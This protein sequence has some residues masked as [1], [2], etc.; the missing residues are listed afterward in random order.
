MRIGDYPSSV[1]IKVLASLPQRIRGTNCFMAF[2]ITTLL[3][4][5]SSQFYALNELSLTYEW[6]FVS[7]LVHFSFHTAPKI[8]I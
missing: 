6:A 1:L 5:N 2:L 7:T 3:V 4:A 8:K